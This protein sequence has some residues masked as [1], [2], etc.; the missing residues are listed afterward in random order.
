MSFSAHSQRKYVQTVLEDYWKPAQEEDVVFLREVSAEEQA[1][2]DAQMDAQLQAEEHVMMI[3]QDFPFSP[4]TEYDGESDQDTVLPAEEDAPCHICGSTYRY[5]V[6]PGPDARNEDTDLST[7]EVKMENEANFLG[8]VVYVPAI[9]S[10]REY[11]M[12]LLEVRGPYAVDTFLLHQGN[13]HYSETP[14]IIA[15]KYTIDKRGHALDR[16]NPQ[17]EMNQIA[18]DCPICGEAYYAYYYPKNNFPCG[19]YVCL[20]CLRQLHQCNGKC[21]LCRA[22]LGRNSYRLTN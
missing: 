9:L 6:C 21:P 11:D 19:H 8:R 12:L 2:M 10:L 5:H 18:G 4:A 20:Q 3:E 14:D 13:F 16:N 15:E 7:E 22:P 1:A 17:S